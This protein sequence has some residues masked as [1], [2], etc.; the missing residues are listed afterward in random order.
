[1]TAKRKYKPTPAVQYARRVYDRWL[2]MEK[3]LTDIENQLRLDHATDRATLHTQAVTIRRLLGQLDTIKVMPSWPQME[4]ELVAANAY[5]A[6][7]LRP[8]AA[9]A[10][11]PT[12]SDAVGTGA[13]PGALVLHVYDPRLYGGKRCTRCRCL[14]EAIEASKLPCLPCKAEA[15]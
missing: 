6:E 12:L 8:G 3:R 15:A 5:I 1:M 10:D 4:R 13:A 9:K 14:R 2:E 7:P 11:V